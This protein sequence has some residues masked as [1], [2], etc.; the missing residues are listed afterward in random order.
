MLK[1]CNAKQMFK[2]YSFHTIINP[3]SPVL[4]DVYEYPT[5]NY[6]S[7]FTNRIQM[8]WQKWLFLAMGGKNTIV[9]QRKVK[10]GLVSYSTILKSKE[11]I[12][13]WSLTNFLYYITL[14]MQSHTVNGH[15]HC[16]RIKKGWFWKFLFI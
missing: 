11:K 3:Y 14:K 7:F 4:I 13:F 6:W 8:V 1:Y 12:V 16:Q 10:I 9:F 5:L 15:R 2:F